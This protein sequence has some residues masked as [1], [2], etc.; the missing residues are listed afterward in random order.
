VSRPA[1]ARPPAVVDKRLVIVAGK[2]GV[3]RTTVAAALAV[4]ATRHGRRVLLCQTR[5]RDRLGQMLGR[6]PVGPE[7]EAAGKNLWAVNMD[8]RAALREYGMML[9]K[10]PAVYRAVFENRPLRAFLRAVPGLY[11]FAMLGKACYHVAERHGGG[12]RF[13]T[14][15]FDGPA[16]GHLLQ[17]LK[18]PRAML[19]AIPAGPLAR[20]AR[21]ADDLLRDPRRTVTHLVT[22]AEE[23]PA[24]EAEDLY[25]SLRDDLAVPMDRL[26]VNALFSDRW[27][28]DGA[29]GRVLDRLDGA[30]LPTDLG[31]AVATAREARARRE[32]Q[33]GH[34][35]RLSASVPLRQVHLPMMFVPS[36]GPAEVQELA[37]AIELQT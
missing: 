30:S 23:M 2:G 20:E 21:A 32:M 24:A 37:R 5:A 9:L 25:R 10:F 31:E 3:G 28:P 33:E 35:Q 29:E 36:M 34:L 18:L 12:D 26:I 13:D 11:E 4:L 6:G 22:L 17:V 27:R 14:V 8:P 19:D 16:T 1:Q 15:I 7:I